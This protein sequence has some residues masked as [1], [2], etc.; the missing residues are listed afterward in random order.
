M[1]RPKIGTLIAAAPR[2]GGPSCFV[3]GVVQAETA[4]GVE[5][6]IEPKTSID[7]WIAEF[8]EAGG[9][10]CGPYGYRLVERTDEIVARIK[11]RAAREKLRG[12]L[13][14]MLS[15]LNELDPDRVSTDTLD[16]ARTEMRRASNLV[17]RALDRIE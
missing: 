1:N 13:V 6:R 4:D 5:V 16:Q 17:I 11:L 7:G 3:L 15:R 2:V 12:H 14:H 8:R 9:A 10:W